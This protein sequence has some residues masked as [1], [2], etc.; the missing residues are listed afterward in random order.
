MTLSSQRTR[1]A[2]GGVYTRSRKRGKGSMLPWIVILGVICLAVVIISW[3]RNPGGEDIAGA[4]GGSEDGQPAAGGNSEYDAMLGASIISPGGSSVGGPRGNGGAGAAVPGGGEDNN[5]GSETSTQRTAKQLDEDIQ[6]ATPKRFETVGETAARLKEGMK[7]IEAGQLVDGRTALSDVL[8]NGGR[9]LAARDAQA[10]RDVLTSV[11]NKLVFSEEVAPGDPFAEYYVIREGDLLSKIAP[12][13][14]VDWR[15]LKRINN[16]RPERIRLGQ[17]IKVVKGP[18]HAV[19][20]KRDYRMDLY[21]RDA[22]HW[23]YVRS[24]R[25][26]VGEDNSTPEGSWVVSS[27]LMDPSWTDPRTGRYYKR[28]DPDIPIGEHW[29]ALKGT[30]PATEQLEG[31]GIHGTNDPDSIGRQMSMGCVRLRNDD[32][33][34]VYEMLDPGDS[35]VLINP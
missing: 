9:N 5:Q 28:S 22:S 15:L 33:A 34:L 1:S 31:Y 8:V 3:P 35:T 26:G 11:N 7:L 20:S 18:F 14:K 12:R 30:E 16:V 29:I 10:I 17:K 2:L 23:I 24:F 13:Y 25:V 21:L 27:K 6:Q 19:V 4:P 32:V